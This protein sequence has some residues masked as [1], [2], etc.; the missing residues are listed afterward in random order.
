MPDPSVARIL[1]LSGYR[2]DQHVFDEVAQTVTCW[3]RPAAANPY[4]CCPGC[5]IST[6]A[7]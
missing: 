4:Y 6:Q 5:G 1:R 3:V 2:V 7:R